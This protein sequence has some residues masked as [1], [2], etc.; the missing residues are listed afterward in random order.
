MMRKKRERFQFMGDTIPPATP[1]HVGEQ[2]VDSVTVNRIVYDSSRVEITESIEPGQVLIPGDNEEVTCFNII[3]LHDVQAITIM[4]DAMGLHRLVTEDIVNT[5]QRP[6]VE[7]Y[8]DYC[9]VVVKELFHDSDN[10]FVKDQVS[11]VLGKNWV[12]VFFERPDTILEQINNR[13]VNTASRLR[14][15]GAD[16]LMYALL[17]MV[18]DN[19]FNVLAKFEDEVEA[20]GD[21]IVDGISGNEQLNRIRG[22]KRN[23]QSIRKATWPLREAI[24]RLERNET[25]LIG[26]SIEHYLRDLYDHTI[27]IM[28]S[29][30]ALRDSVTG[31]LDM[32]MSSQSNRMNRIMQVLTIVSTIF[33]PL[34]FIA[35]IYGMNFQNM[36]ELSW[37]F[38]YPLVLLIMSLTGGGLMLFFK[39]KR[40]L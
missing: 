4:C 33:I 8:D 6:K 38:G 23:I 28:E 1:H 3:G 2:F 10:T 18:I 36:P 40:W 15:Q 37:D 32:H 20:V 16:Y 14:K 19:Y 17:D 34:T 13:I 31:L 29:I 12:M 39:L 27:Q 24:G 26:R 9:F 25:P 5:S 30:E 21:E 7:F 35:G 11:I 22:L